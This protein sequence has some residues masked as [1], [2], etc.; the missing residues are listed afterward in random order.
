MYKFIIVLLISS[1]PFSALAIEGSTPQPAAIK[2]LLNSGRPGAIQKAQ[3]GTQMVDK[4]I[5]VLRASYD[6][7]VLGGASGS[8]LTA[9]DEGGKPAVIPDNAI[10]KQVIFDVLQNP[11]GTGA[12]IAVGVNGSTTNLKG[13]TSVGSWTGLVAGVPVGT[14]ATAIK[15]TSQSAV[16]Y[17]VTAGSLTQGKIDAFIEYYVGQ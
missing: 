10:I 15:T 6:F 14:A 1:F 2:A 16:T 4:K 9:L 5:Q 7:G 3:L 12:T 13:F 8:T 11:V 17:R